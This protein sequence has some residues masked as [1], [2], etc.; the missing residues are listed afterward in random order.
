VFLLYI[1][2]NLQERK[3]QKISE[4]NLAASVRAI[5]VIVKADPK[6]VGFGKVG[7]FF[8]QD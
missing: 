6:S 5:A 8:K 7:S 3:M 4:T 1:K 2:I